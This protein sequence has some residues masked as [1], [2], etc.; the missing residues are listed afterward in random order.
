LILCLLSV[1]LFVTK[2]H[3]NITRVASEWNIRVGRLQVF[4]FGLAAFLVC[5]TGVRSVDDQLSI[6]LLKPRAGSIGAPVVFSFRES[7]R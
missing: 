5:L 3:H 6:E 4:T 7:E 2:K 1:V